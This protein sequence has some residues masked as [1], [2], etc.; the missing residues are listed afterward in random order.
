MGQNDGRRKRRKIQSDENANSPRTR[1][2][3]KNS[4]PQDTTSTPLDV[5]ESEPLNTLLFLERWA[6]EGSD[7]ED[8]IPNNNENDLDLD[9]EDIEFLNQL[10]GPNPNLTSA[11][12]S[13]VSST[14]NEF[15]EVDY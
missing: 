5:E 10:I 3:A 14:N 12:A 2:T 9:Y 7:D 13:D 1:N 6:Q 15:L 4:T 8:Y 11:I